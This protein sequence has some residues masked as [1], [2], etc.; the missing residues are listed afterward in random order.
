MGNQKC[1]K[2]RLLFPD[3]LVYPLHAEGNYY[4][5]CGVCSLE[6]IRGVNNK[7]YQFPLDSLARAIYKETKLFRAKK[8]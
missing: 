3:K 5:F 7:D 8:T 6:V 1:H 2:C 4:D